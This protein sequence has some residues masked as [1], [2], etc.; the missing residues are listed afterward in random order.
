MGAADAWTGGL[1]YE[2]Y[3]GRWSRAV[4]RPFVSGAASGH[5][6][7]V[8]VPAGTVAS[9]RGSPAASYGLMFWFTWNRLSGSYF[10]F[11]STSRS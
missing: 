4:A 3:V 8:P 2:S 6:H 7:E 5:A 1:D 11:M 9:C 10:L